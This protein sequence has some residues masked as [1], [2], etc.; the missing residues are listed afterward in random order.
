MTPLSAF[1]RQAPLLHGYTEMGTAALN[2]ESKNLCLRRYCLYS[3]W[4]GRLPGLIRTA[5]FA[6]SSFR[7]RFL[8]PRKMSRSPHVYAVTWIR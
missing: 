5:A 1:S 6:R 3:D 4:A 7:L 2:E 8:M